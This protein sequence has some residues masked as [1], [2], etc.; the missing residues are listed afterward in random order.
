MKAFGRLLLATALIVPAGIA[1]AESAGSTPSNTATCTT[2]T[3]TL[4]LSPG[5]RSFDK[6]GQ[7]IRNFTTGS[8]NNPG[9]PGEISG[10][11]GIGIAEATG[12]TFAFNLSGGG[13]LT[14][15]SIRKKTFTG[16]GVVDWAE[17]GSNAGQ[18]SRLRV[19]LT[20]NGYKQVTFKGVVD[21]NYLKGTK[22]SGTASIPDKLKPVGVG[23]GECQN[24]KRVKTL[25]YENTSDTTL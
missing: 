5:L 6:A 24:K 1:T 19:Q 4:R 14:C 20:F 3:G 7:T 22:L 13:N 18:I 17:D 9:S 8:I 12:G 21:S 25:D 2:N 10:C 11:T 16:R 15:S 23:G